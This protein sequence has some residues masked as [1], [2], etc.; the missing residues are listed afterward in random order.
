MRF[1][2][3][4]RRFQSGKSFLQ[5]LTRLVKVST[6]VSSFSDMIPWR[7]RTKQGWWYE[8]G[9]LH[10]SHDASLHTI[11]SSFRTHVILSVL[12]GRDSWTTIKS[13]VCDETFCTFAVSIF[14]RFSFYYSNISF[15]KSKGVFWPSILT[16]L[17]SD[18]KAVY[19]DAPCSLR[20]A[21]AFP[22]VASLPPIFRRE[23]GDDRKCV[24]CSQANAPW[25]QR[26]RSL[27]QYVL[28]WRVLIK[29]SMDSQTISTCLSWNKY[30]LFV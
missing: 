24:C 26:A 25:S 11:L 12:Q 3:R 2:S 13:D 21:D 30:L 29:L 19:A 10:I 1:V 15:V 28:F 14:L 17:P 8:L 9:E 27:L 7:K 20:T 22:V 23:R 18:H 5:R 4:F 16:N 6:A